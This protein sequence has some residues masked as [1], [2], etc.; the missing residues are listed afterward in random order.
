NALGQV[1]PTGNPYDNAFAPFLDLPSEIGKGYMTVHSTLTVLG[2]ECNEVVSAETLMMVKEHVIEAYGPVVHTIGAGASGGAIQQYT[3]ANSY[4]GLIDGGNAIISFPDM[5]TT[6]V[7]D[8]DCLLLER[9]FRADPLR[10][11]ELTQVAVT[12]F[13]T[14]Q[15]CVDWVSSYAN[16]VAA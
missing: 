5:E 15:I 8:A 11:T 7:T 16:T 1:S 13:R 9:V 6:F 3:A 2:I 14:R 4:P 12:G 10:W